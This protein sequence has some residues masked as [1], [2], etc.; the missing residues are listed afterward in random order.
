M[1]HLQRVQFFEPLL[2]KKVQFFESFFQT[3]SIISVCQNF[4]KK[5]SLGHIQKNGFNF[6]ES[7]QKKKERFN[8]VSCIRKRGSILWVIFQKKIN[9]WS[10]LKKR[11]GSLSHISKRRFNSLSRIRKKF[12]SVSRITKKF[13]SLKHFFDF[14]FLKKNE[15][16]FLRKKVQ[17]GES[18][19]LD[20]TKWPDDHTCQVS[21]TQNQWLD[22]PRSNQEG[23]TL[24][25]N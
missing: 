7:C 15:S 10:H 23:Q 14:F 12:N 22:S 24:K 5:N 1:S 20:T 17:F 2:K 19:F 16:F 3:G 4:C 21:N 8:S 6:Y 25:E 18:Y 9:S 13:N 11:L